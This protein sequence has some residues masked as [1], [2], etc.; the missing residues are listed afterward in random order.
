MFPVLFYQCF[1]QYYDDG[2]CRFWS[3]ILTERHDRSIKRF[4]RGMVNHLLNRR[5]VS[6]YAASKTNH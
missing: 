5:G 6:Q 2:S 4:T 3:A 1:W